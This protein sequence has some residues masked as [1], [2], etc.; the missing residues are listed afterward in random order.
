MRCAVRRSASA[1]PAW[2]STATIAPCVLHQRRQVG[3]LAAGRRTQV[4]HALAGHGRQHA[5]DGHR[6]TRLRHQQSVAPLGRVERVEGR[7]EHQRLGQPFDRVRR[8]ALGERLARRSAACWPAARLGRLVVGGHQRAR[9]VGAERVPP[10][11]RDPLGMRVLERGLR[12]RGVGER[13][14]DRPRLAR[15]ASQDRVDQAGAA[16][17][18]GLGQLDRLADGGVRRDAVQEGQLEDPEPQRGQDRRVELAGGRRASRSITWSSVATRWTVP[19]ASCVASARSRA[20]SFGAAPRRAA[21]GRP[22]PLLEDAPDDRV[23]AAAC[24]RDAMGPRPG[25]R[26]S[27]SCRAFT[28][29]GHLIGCRFAAPPGLAVCGAP[30]AEVHF[31]V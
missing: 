27:F 26:S 31:P 11:L 14:D 22:T 19:Y 1:R 23:R 8:Q 2:R 13:G 21:R 15:G 25:G 28:R 6:G 18:V 5:R 4:Q 10:E 30:R 29:A 12:G 7:V 24:G 9:R 17:R 3:G 20:S 16:R